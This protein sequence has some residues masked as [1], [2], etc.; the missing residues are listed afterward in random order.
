M[1]SGLSLPNFTAASLI[2]NLLF[3]S[4]GFV[5]L[6]YGRKMDAWRPMFIGL[7]LMAYTYFVE[8]TVLLVG[9]G[10]ALTGALFLFRE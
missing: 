10:L 2:A 9:I 1:P 8:S 7:I 5:A 6:V 3:S 4:V